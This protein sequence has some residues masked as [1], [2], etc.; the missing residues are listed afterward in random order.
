LAESIGSLYPTQIPSLSDSANIQA[1]LRLYH[2]GDASYNIN[3]TNPAL[4]P[5]NSIAGALSSLQTQITN[6]SGTLGVQASTWT[7]KGALVTATAASTVQVLTVSLPTD[8]AK[9]LTVDS[10]TGTGLKWALPDVTLSNAV[11]LTNK[12]LTN[13]TINAGSGTIVLPGS[14]T[15]AQTADGSIVWD[16]DSD[17]LT[18]GTG[19]GRK[20]MVDTDSTQTLT[21]KTLT[22]PTL[23]SP[24]AT[25]IYLSETGATIVFEGSTPDNFETT[26]G[27]IDPTADRAINLPNVDGTVITTGNLTSIT[28]VGTITAGTWNGTAIAAN[29][30]GTGQTSY[31]IGD[32]LYASGTTALSKL[33]GVATGNALISGGVATA[34]SWGKIGLTT[35]VSGTLPVTS[36]GTGLTAVTTGDILYASASNTLAAL[37]GVATGNALISGGV[38]V[39]PSYGKIGLTTHIS[40]TLAI[41]N[42]GTNITTY[43]TG[44]I[45]YASAAN[46]LAKLTI[47]GNGQV[48]TISGGIPTWQN[49]VSGFANPMTTLGDI[50]YGAASGTATRLGGNTSTTASFLSST[51][52]GTNATAPVWTSSTGT[53]NVVLSAS[54]ALSGTPTAPTAAANTNTT[55][56]ATTAYAY[57]LEEWVVI[58]LSDEVTNITTGTAKVTWRA[59]YAM[60]LTQIPRASLATASTSGNPTVDINEN[61]TS[62]LGA[63]KLSIDANEKTSVT[64][65]TPTTL[66][67]TGIADDAEI[68][69]DIDVA[70][71]GA[72]GLKV[73]L[74][75]KRA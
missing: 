39:A 31:A 40:G 72:K 41:G 32:I 6:V 8:D 26:L 28:T 55:Q 53:G 15:P 50:I 18:I 51:G 49:A 66:A 11:T 62:V 21:N 68:T 9:V 63:N 3:N 48:L 56:I 65:A 67:D 75:Y 54:P 74:Y 37:A 7:G 52:N 44:D 34:P 58:A 64:A 69:F 42:G 5:A 45:L 47:G 22:S 4:L 14:N 73:T 36:G 25:N 12:T 33:A 10:T 46:T 20:T 60:T 57:Q 17:L 29:Y 1:A 59:P 71:T 16:L 24:T 70:G 13:P 38:G 30:G 23:T 61:G 43:A 27:V 2:Y 35:H 19:A